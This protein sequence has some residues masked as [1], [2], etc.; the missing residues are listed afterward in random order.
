MVKTGGSTAAAA[1]AYDEALMV[2]RIEAVRRLK[3]QFAD[4]SS[5]ASQSV[6]AYSDL[7][8]GAPLTL[9]LGDSLRHSLS[10]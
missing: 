7:L 10:I 8:D 4:P 1:A 2:K 6:A 3:E 9:R 5:V